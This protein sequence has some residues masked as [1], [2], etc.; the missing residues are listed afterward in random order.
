MTDTVPGH[1]PHSLIDRTIGSD[2]DRSGNH[3]FID[4]CVLRGSS[5]K[6]D[7]SGVVSF[8]NQA[9]QVTTVQHEKRSDVI[10]GHDS[11]R[12]VNCRFRADRPDVSALLLQYLRN[13]IK[14]LHM[15]TVRDDQTPREI[16]PAFEALYALLRP[17]K[18]R[19]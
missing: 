19:F 3:Y 16:R 15:I 6:D 12:F 4:H 18:F 13:S 5:F 7:L 10:V 11:E 8:R 14:Y 2:R 1:D 17:Q 9:R